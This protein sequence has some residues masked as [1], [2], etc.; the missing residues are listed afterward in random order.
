MAVG[1][2][3]ACA[4]CLVE[5]RERPAQFS[6]PTRFVIRWPE[7]GNQMG[8]ALA[9]LGNGQIGQQRHRFSSPN[10]NGLMV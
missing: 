3:P 7:Q 4:Q 10:V 1:I 8:A 6:A 2:Q 5:C 9:A